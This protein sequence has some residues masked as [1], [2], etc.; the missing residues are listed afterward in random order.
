MHVLNMCSKGQAL[1]IQPLYP[2]Q[3]L[4][5]DKK[6][7]QKLRNL[8]EFTHRDSK[9]IPCGNTFSGKECHWRPRFI[10]K[11][12]RQGFFYSSSVVVCF[13][14]CQNGCHFF[15]LLLC[16]VCGRGGGER[17]NAVALREPWEASVKE[18]LCSDADLGRDSDAS[19]G[20]ILTEHTTSSIGKGWCG[21][22]WTKTRRGGVR[23]AYPGCEALWSMVD[24][25]RERF[26]LHSVVRD[27]LSYDSGPNREPLKPASQ[28]NT[29]QLN[30]T[31][32]DWTQLNP[33]SFPSLACRF[34]IGCSLGIFSI[35]FDLV[36]L[37]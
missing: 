5:E 29:T 27:S 11:R 14:L 16:L 33:T 23:N 6:T 17:W 25:L 31:R 37:L 1:S 10:R 28:N 24:P 12:R 21:W 15:R 2:P 3:T 32:L 13:V 20:P 22:G 4:R 19:P 9:F 18:P 30:L 35:Y 7:L 8:W 34:S 36:F 26:S